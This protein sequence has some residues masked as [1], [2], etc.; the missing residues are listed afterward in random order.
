MESRGESRGESSSR[1][2]AVVLRVAVHPEARRVFFFLLAGGS[3]A[4]VNLGILAT[5]TNPAWWGWDYLPAVLVATEVSVMFSFILN[6]R[7]TFRALAVHA[8][9]WGER[10]LRFHLAAAAGQVLTILLGLLLI[11]KLGLKALL[12]QAISLAVVTVFNFMVQRFLT[13]AARTHRHP[14]T[15]SPDVATAFDGRPL[16]EARA[17]VAL[18]VEPIPQVAQPVSMYA[19]ARMRPPAED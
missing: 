14:P 17:P 18:D 8:G 7:I 15:T 6:D 3:A 2:R 16:S 12:A 11:H 9:G 13:Y 5:L 10:C 1:L 4:L 19:W